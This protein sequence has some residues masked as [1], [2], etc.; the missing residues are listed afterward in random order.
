MTLWDA[1]TRQV[2]ARLGNYQGVEAFAF[3]PDSSRM[4]VS[5]EPQHDIEIWEVAT[6]TR[7]SRMEGHEG[8]IICLAWLPDGRRLVSG[9]RDHT[10]KMWDVASGQ[11]L[12]SLPLDDSPD[13]NIRLLAVSPD[14][15]R[16]AATCRDTITVW[17]DRTRPERERWRQVG[18]K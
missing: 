2:A 3:S 12:L 17:D 10:L 15:H 8:E 4:A 1:T 9:G 13:N 11:E 5:V 18:A 16:V 14:G 7:I 6:R